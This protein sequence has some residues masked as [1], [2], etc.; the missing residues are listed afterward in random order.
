[1]TCHTPF[2][3]TKILATV[4]PSCANAAV[5]ANLIE[6]GVRVF[7]IN[8]S[9]GDFDSFTHALD[10]IREGSRRA[11]ITVGV[12]GDLSG[13][14]IRVGKVQPGGIELEAGQSVWFQQPP[15][16][17]SDPRLASSGQPPEADTGSTVTFSTTYPPFI[18]DANPGDRL[19]IDDGAVRLLVTGRDGQGED[20]R[21][22]CRVTIGGIVTSSKGINLPDTDV[23]APSVTEYDWRCVDWAVKNELD[24]LALS[25]VR[26][27]ADVQELKSYLAE[28]TAKAVTTIPVIAKIEKPQALTD[29]EAIVQVADG[30]M[31]ARGDL[32]VEMDPAK[33]PG[34]QKRTIRLA[35][36]YG[37]PV[38][39]ATQ[40]LQSM[41]ESATATRA[42]VS[43]VA[44][45]IY[46]GASAVMLS[47]ETAVGRYPI[48]AV[49]TM[50]RIAVATQRDLA[51]LPPQGRPPIK[52]QESRYR[53]AALAHGV[54]V[55]VRDLHAKLMGVWSRNGGGAR[56]LSQNRPSIPI[57]AASCNP[58]ALR[59]MNL[60][61]G[62]VPVYMEQPNSFEDF[63]SQLDQLIIDRA[64]A[65]QGDQVV[66]LAGQPI[67]YPGMTNALLIRY[68]GGVCRV[69]EGS[70]TSLGKRG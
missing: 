1:M 67:D 19:L 44:N 36:D 47:G 18:S 70:G 12:L 40:M 22:I 23:S 37:K 4:G 21:L 7:R 28:I 51:E 42:E 64:W 2:I 68:L 66:L 27:A 59:R 29:L 35:Q 34:I 46:D 16:I 41:I 25:F 10:G 62:V 24:F 17:A 20:Q 15:I 39:V 43:D 55:V 69:N 63:A 11:G 26:Q 58:P 9:H 38:I 48:Q 52:L 60:L 13:P 32:G 30:L 31:V 57:I 8:F 6:Q 61:Y 50:A 54:N 56:Y 14:K 45:A 53:T 49:Q 65:N 3:L 33:V 5:L